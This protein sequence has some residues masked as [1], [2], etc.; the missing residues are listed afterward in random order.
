[1][2]RSAV[3][4]NLPDGEA[5]TGEAN[6][7]REYGLWVELRTVGGA[8]P[9]EALFQEYLPYARAIA[10]SLFRRRVVD[11]I[12]FEDY[13]QFACVGLLESIDRFD[14]ERGV[15]F[16]TFCTSRVEGSVLDGIQ[17]LTEVQEQMAFRRRHRKE[18]VQ[19][20]TGL[21]ALD[22][23]SSLVDVTMGL[24]IGFLLEGTSLFSD[25]SSEAQRP[26]PYSS[27]ES[28]QTKRVLASAV[29]R[30]PARQR[31]LIAYHYLHGMPFERIADL[32]GVTAGRV[33]Q[34]HKS[35]LQS[36]RSALQQSIGDAG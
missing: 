4:D 15:K 22:T 10:A 13:L 3:S 16:T 9:R 14:A 35:A 7:G 21:D 27:A 24:A 36:L 25:E 12:S 32:F 30:L 1:M 29:D 20:L 33:S 26:N 11:E 34:L 31:N 2:E 6:S 8:E 28:N 19:S 23:F 18:R 5:G 17:H